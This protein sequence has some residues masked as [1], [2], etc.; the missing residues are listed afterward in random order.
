MINTIFYFPSS[1]TFQDYLELLNSGQIAQRTIVFAEA[2][3]AVYKGGKKYGGLSTQEFEALLDEQQ[4]NSWITDEIQ[5]VRDT[6]SS[7]NESIQNL[8]ERIAD[9]I[10][11][12]QG[13]IASANE[14][15]SGLNT[16]ISTVNSNLASA[17]AN[18][19]SAIQTKVESM[20][21]DS[22]W[23][24]Q[25]FPQG[26]THWDSSW[27]SNLES[28][29]TTVGYWDIDSQTGVKTTKWSNLQAA[30]DSVSLSVNDLKT[31][32]NLTR[33]MTASIESLISDDITALNLGTTYA[34]ISDV[35]NVEKVV[36]WFYSGI[37]SSAQ[38]DK[39]IAQMSAMSKSDFVA[40]ISDIRTQVDKV[41]NGDFVAQTEVSSK[42]GDTISNMLLQ[43]SSDNALAA[44]SAKADAN[45]DNISA[46]VLGMT[47]STSTANLS[48]SVSNSLNN[49]T[50]GL[51]STTDANTAI[52]KA[53]ATAKTDIYS[54]IGAKDANDNF[55]ALSALKVQ[56]DKLANGEYVAQSEVLAKVGDSVTSMMLDASENPTYKVTIKSAVS[57]A[58]AVSTISAKI[59]AL[60]SVS[61]NDIF[62]ESDFTTLPNQSTTYTNGTQYFQFT[63]QSNVLAALSAKTDTNSDD[64]S[65]LVLGMTGS[66]STA[67][68][69]TAVSNAMSGLV[70]TA[71]SNAANATG[72]AISSAKTEIYSAIH[73]KDSN[74]NF[75]SIAALK[76]QSDQDHASISLLA[77][78][79]A[80]VSGVVAK[81]ELGSSV[82][83]L[84]AST[85]DAQNPTAKANVVAVVKNNKSQLNLTA[86]DV[87]ID[88]YLTGGSATFKGDVEATSFT[89]GGSNDYGITVLSGAFDPTDPTVNT[90][91]AYF[92]YDSEQGGV[93]MYFYCNNAWKRIDLASASVSE[94]PEAFAE[95]ILYTGTVFGNYLLSDSTFTRTYYNRVTAKYYTTTSAT[96]ANLLTATG[97]KFHTGWIPMA[98][99]ANS[100]G[101]SRTDPTVDCSTIVAFTYIP[102][103]NVTSNL[104][105]GQKPLYLI[106]PRLQPTGEA[107]YNSS[108]VQLNPYNDGDNTSTTYIYKETYQDGV[109]SSTSYMHYYYVADE[110]LW[111][112]AGQ[113]LPSG[114]IAQ[115]SQT[116]STSDAFAYV[117]WRIGDHKAI[118]KNMSSGDKF[119]IAGG[120]GKVYE[121]STLGK[122]IVYQVS[123]WSNYQSNTTRQ[124]TNQQL[125]DADL[126]SPY[127]FND[128]SL[129]K[130]DGWVNGVEL[131]PDYI[132]PSKATQV[133]H[134]WHCIPDVPYT[135]PTTQPA[136]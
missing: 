117:V 103:A 86:Q 16:S 60:A 75:I 34:T 67:N 93:T 94:D 44:L 92:A 125:S 113:P 9:E 35:D 3:K 26:Q 127:N 59:A 21:N 105:L 107:R 74:D 52:G 6:I 134:I 46:I 28:Y 19:D 102:Q 25:N 121:A 95:G 118:V 38:A 71:T 53:I 45:E 97:Y 100:W 56:T 77:T 8:N 33:A 80:D 84:F 98:P 1:L 115:N 15:I 10:Q 119:C 17:V 14:T 68:L 81:S 66:S 50:S 135:Y 32:G 47:G 91:K 2:Q 7:T 57:G 42:V 70:T 37:K 63:Q 114:I 82:A 123:P 109:E 22:Q 36:E 27:N 49:L 106:P 24:G 11:D 40:A 116:P 126:L 62:V 110:V 76:T 64:I 5:S 131:N 79:K 69:S 31:N 124:Y 65:A 111:H 129:L 20:F 30:L 18:R 29:L 23:L 73:A 55:I 89:T 43:S 99:S 41:A 136:S 58:T 101:G 72:N 87:N 39:T 13:D 78:N 96:A 88:G 48:T 12:I 122:Q 4:H 132:D 51:I 128:Y 133:G 120:N 90:H 83:S 130:V 54:R 108:G 104:G 61:V 85:G 112:A